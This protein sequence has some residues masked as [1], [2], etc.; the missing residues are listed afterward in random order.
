MTRHTPHRVRTIR[1]ENGVALMATLMVMVLLSA[2]LVGFTAMVASENRIV[3]MDAAGA[4]SFYAVHAGLE[5]LTH[6]LGILFSVDFS[7]SGSQVRALADESRTVE[8]R[9]LAASFSPF[10]PKY[11]DLSAQEHF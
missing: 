5:K 11:P 3:G 4:S 2:L 6:D 7:P 9:I 10:L 1:A 8:K